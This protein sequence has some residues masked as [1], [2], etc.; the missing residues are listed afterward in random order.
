[1][2]R[3]IKELEG[4]T[5][6]ATD[7]EIGHV[8][9]FYF[10]DETWTV[11]YLVVDTGPW[12]FGRQVLISP[13]A[14][15]DPDWI[16]Q[17]LPVILTKE[18]VENSPD[19][20]LDRPVSRQHELELHQYYR[21]TAYWGAPLEPGPTQPGPVPPSAVEEP[22]IEK[23]QGDPNLRSTDEVTGYH[24]QARDGEVGH[25]EDFLVAEDSWTIH[26]LVVDTRNW[27]PGRKVLVSPQWV[28]TV[29]WLDSKVHVDL[30]R[31]TI[32]NSP[33]YDPSSPVS[34]TYEEELYD[35]YGLPKYWV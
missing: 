34:R 2:L 29:N 7:G 4:Y 8:D 31:E 1:M 25:V 35:H 26:Y 18:Q 30:V 5:I 11:R 32:K 23:A 22:V 20:N 14:L 6:L 9:E 16:S 27:L 17:R 33:E 10:D 3:S 19:I 12:L 13:V 15:D 24:I 21:W 28:E